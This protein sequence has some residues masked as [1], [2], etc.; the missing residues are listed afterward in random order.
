MFEATS[1]YNECGDAFII[2]NDGKTIK[3]KKRRFIPQEKEES[4][5]HV[6]NRYYSWR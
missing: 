6:G 4:D 1:R 5:Y 3:Y 2:T